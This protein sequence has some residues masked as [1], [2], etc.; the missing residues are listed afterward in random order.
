MIMFKKQTDMNASG[1]RIL[2][3]P[4]EECGGQQT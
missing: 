4:P 3:Q 1:I 2:S